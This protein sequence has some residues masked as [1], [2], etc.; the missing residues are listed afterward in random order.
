MR[1]RWRW[2]L[3]NDEDMDNY[4]D[5]DADA[6]NAGIMEMNDEEMAAAM[7][8]M[9]MM[10][11]IVMLIRYGWWWWWDDNNVDTNDVYGNDDNDVYE[12]ISYRCGFDVDDEKE[13][14]EEG[15]GSSSITH[16]CRVPNRPWRRT[17]PPRGRWSRP[18]PSWWPVWRMGWTR[19][20]GRGGLG[21]SR[22]LARGLVGRWLDRWLRERVTRRQWIGR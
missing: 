13:E 7:M 9:M 3:D 19:R 8:M 17:Y 14:D 4:G 21:P 11:A 10:M 6:H 18:P 15:R 2:W 16:H 5:D 22:C 12:E 1:S 20:A